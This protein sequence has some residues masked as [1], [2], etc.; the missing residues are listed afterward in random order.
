ME[1]AL[2]QADFL[3]SLDLRVLQAFV[4]YLVSISIVCLD[5]MKWCGENDIL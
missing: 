1:D 5:W 3:K 2:Q 4:L